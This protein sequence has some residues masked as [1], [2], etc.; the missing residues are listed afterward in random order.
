ML[1]GWD[2]VSELRPPTGLLFIPVTIYC[3]SM[4]PRGMILTGKDEEF[5]EKPVPVPLLLPQIPHGLTQAW[6]RSSA[7]RGR[8]LTVWDTERPSKL[9]INIIKESVF[10]IPQSGQMP[11]KYN[12]LTKTSASI[13]PNSAK[14]SWNVSMKLYYA[15]VYTSLKL[16]QTLAATSILCSWNISSWD[17]FSSPS[18]RTCCLLTQNLQRGLAESGVLWQAVKSWVMKST[19]AFKSDTS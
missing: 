19:A 8:R 10:C 5:G 9:H 12:N 2:Y 3:M 16:R 4:E 15:N 7:V 18:S 14:R 1:M 13:L 11:R 17:E 6:T